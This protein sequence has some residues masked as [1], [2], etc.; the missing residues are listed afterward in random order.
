[1]GKAFDR[2]VALADSA[3]VVVTVAVGD[4]RDGCLVGFHSQASIAPP[5]YAVW[6]ST[7]NR[8]RV[9]AQQATHLGVHLLGEHQHDLAELFGGQTGDEVDK[10]I[11]VRWA[12]GHGGAPMLLD[13][14][15]RFV[16][17]AQVLAVP[18][19]ADHVCVLLAPE[20]AGASEPFAPLRLHHAVDI[21][22]GHPA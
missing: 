8:T 7:A 5:G 6:L 3:M 21:D 2:F 9:L 16:G 15:N 11:G 19:R 1:M 22:P 13:C 12:P 4:K 14:P 18:D 20:S 17:R 10:L